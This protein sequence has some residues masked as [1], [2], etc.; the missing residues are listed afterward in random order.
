MN[1]MLRVT[2]LTPIETS[3]TKGRFR[4]FGGLVVGLRRGRLAVLTIGMVITF[5]SGPGVFLRPPVP[6]PISGGRWRVPVPVTFYT[7]HYARTESRSCVPTAFCSTPSD[8][9]TTGVDCDPTAPSGAYRPCRHRKCWCPRIHYRL[10]DLERAC[11]NEVMH[12]GGYI[13]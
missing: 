4:T 12:S 1:W 7:L 9:R 8:N 3:T 6:V 5:R 13:P 11:G 2:A 10:P